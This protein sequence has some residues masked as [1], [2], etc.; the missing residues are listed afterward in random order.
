MFAH[1]RKLLPL[2]IAAALVSGRV[3]AVGLGDLSLRS[4]LGKPLQAEVA[5]SHM[6]DLSLDQLKV[7]IGSAADYSAL[8]VEYNYLHS[9]LKIEPFTKN[10][11]NYVRIT[12]SEAISEPY[13]DFVLNLRWPQGQVVREFTVLLDPAPI[14]AL[15]S[16]PQPESVPTESPVTAQQPVEQRLAEVVRPRVKPRAEPAVRH[17]AGGGYV[18]QRGD[19]LWRLAAKLRPSTAVSVEQMM[20]ALL[21]ANPDAFIKGDAARLKEGATIDVAAAERIATGGAAPTATA[22]AS[23]PAPQAPQPAPAPLVQENAALKAQ[24]ADLSE[25]VST[26]NA[27]LVESNDRLHEMEARLDGLMQQ[28]QQQRAAVAGDTAE[29]LTAS[30]AQPGAMINQVNAAE[31]KPLPKAHTPWWVHLLYWSGIAA[32]AG[33]AVREHFWP[34]RRLAMATASAGGQ[35]FEPA[36][37]GAAVGNNWGSPEQYWQHPGDEATE[38]SLDLADVL[39]AADGDSPATEIELDLPRQTDEPVDASISAGVFVAF[40][41][42][43]EAERLLREALLQ[44]RERDD[45]KLQLLDVYLQSNQAAAFE[46]LAQA[47]EDSAASSETLAELA[48]LRDS[49]QARG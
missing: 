29:H 7:Q 16:R 1:R 9:Q 21:A 5:L 11:Q 41:R 31:L 8:G 4:Y 32:A 43:D 39:P 33:W 38:L 40:G 15:A 26:L 35:R 23:A 48:V 6:G 12:T 13:L 27:S 28:F 37:E 20:A 45:L 24:V 14:T 42:F 44:N 10:G 46:K 47:I 17:A 25:N 2:Y 3:A 30:V 34:T 22:V 18:T 19:S 49:F 36:P